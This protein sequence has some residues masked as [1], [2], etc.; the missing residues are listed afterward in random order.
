MSIHSFSLSTVRCLPEFFFFK[1]EL[2]RSEMRRNKKKEGKGHPNYSVLF[3][4]FSFFSFS[5]FPIEK[6]FSGTV[7]QKILL[8]RPEDRSQLEKKLKIHMDSIIEAVAPSASSGRGLAASPDGH[9][10]GANGPG[11]H[12]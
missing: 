12:A 7:F 10:P 2:S 4:F 11:L 3:R 5:L 6:K 8:N 1:C 9:R